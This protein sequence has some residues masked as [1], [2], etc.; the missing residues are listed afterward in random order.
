VPIHLSKVAEKFQIR[1]RPLIDHTVRRAALTYN[2][3]TNEFIISLNP[4][5][6]AFDIERATRND[7]VK[8]QRFAYA[9][10]FAHRF[11]YV[12]RGGE[13][14]RALSIVTAA[15]PKETR[16]RTIR[17]LSTVE[18]RICNRAADRLLLPTGELTRY[19]SEV[20]FGSKASPHLIWEVVGNVANKFCVSRR[21]ALRRVVSAKPE[22]LRQALGESFCLLLLGRSSSTGRGQGASRIRL[23]DYWWPQSANGIDVVQVFPGLA[24]E[25]L[26]ED[27][28]RAVA[29]MLGNTRANAGEISRMIELRSKHDTAKRIPSQFTGVWMKW[30]SAG[31]QQLVMF[32]VIG[33]DD[34]KEAIAQK[35]YGHIK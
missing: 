5:D 28:A 29:S 26:G 32:G 23:L 3:K 16:L 34:K 24:I 22:D 35:S 9:H 19:V 4:T 33:E 30:M 6:K 21:C 27:L 1:R 31:Y 7:E 14:I 11:L 10:E 2:S 20:L 25:H 8:F 17:I 12:P 13:W 18:E 15:F